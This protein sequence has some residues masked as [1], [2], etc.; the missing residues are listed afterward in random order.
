MSSAHNGQGSVA[1]TPPE[2]TEGQARVRKISQ[3]KADP[4]DLEE[5]LSELAY[6][7]WNYDF[8]QAVRRLDALHPHLQGI[9][10]SDRVEDDPI[11]FCQQPSLAFPQNTLNRYDPPASNRPGRLFVAFMGML[12]PHGPLPLHLTEYAH[13]R[14]LHVK[15]FTFSRFLDVFNHR[16]ISLFYRAWAVNQM[17]AS[18]DRSMAAAGYDPNTITDELRER[19][20]LEDEDPYAI[21]IGSLIGLGMDS[22]RLRDRVP[23][24]AKLHYAGRLS[25]GAPGP[26]GLRAI[27][28]DYFGVPVM[29]EEFAGHWLDLPPSAYCV[30]GGDPVDKTPSSLGGPLGGAVVGKRVWDCQGKFRIRLGPMSY[31]DYQ[32]FLPVTRTARRL[33]AW[34]RNYVGDEFAWEAQVILRRDEVP[35]VRLGG[36]AALGWTTWSYSGSAEEDRA[37]LTIR[38][39]N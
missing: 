14:E 1:E 33:E 21:Y 11:R 35:P 18:Y 24:T 6:E 19:A 25:A 3:R 23:D 4:K 38:S 13:E 2:R 20:L 32:R 10:R 27:L 28:Q 7:T 12:G 8:F 39:R 15:D 9:G 16:L 26:E 36:G 31:E 37:D 17:P 34:I 30:L 22:L 29:I 5:F